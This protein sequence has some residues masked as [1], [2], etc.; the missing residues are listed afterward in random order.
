ML[1]FKRRYHEGIKNREI[2]ETIRY[3]YHWKAEKFKPNGIYYCYDLGY[4]LILSIAE[5]TLNDLNEED[6]KRCGEDSLEA[7]KNNCLEVYGKLFPNKDLH[8]DKWYK[9]EFKYLYEEKPE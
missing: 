2:T 6:A 1:V 9:I 8:N 7:L 4:V 5:V 3:W